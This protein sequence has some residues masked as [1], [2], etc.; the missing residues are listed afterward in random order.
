MLPFGETPMRY[1]G[2]AALVFCLALAAGTAQAE[3]KYDPGVSDSEIKLGQSMPYS[4]PASAYGALGLAELAYFKMLNE[5][6]GVNGRKINL[7]SLDDGYAPPK[8]VEQTR[9]LVE[10]E[11]VLAI[12]QSLGTPSNT[13]IQKY[14]NNKKVP[15]LF[16]ASGASKWGDPE[17]FPWTISWAPNYAAEAR[18]YAKAILVEHPDAK[19]AVLYQNDD[20]GKDYVEAFHNQLGAKAASLIVKEVSYEV[21][22][23]TI[24]SQVVTLKGAD[25]DTFFNVT[26]PKFAAMSIRKAYDI[27]WKPV[28]YLANVSNS[29]ASVLR[30]AG[31]EKAVGIISAAY[32]KDPND[33]QW[34]DDPAYKD[35]L[36]WMNKY[37]PLAD[38]GDVFNVYGYTVAETMAQVLRQC[39]DELTREN[40]MRQAA[41]LKDLRLPMLLPGIAINTSATRFYPIKQQRLERFDG[42]AWVLFGDVIG[43]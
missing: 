35:W 41:S 14:L 43:G 28:Q 20:F 9:K 32:L 1:R 42:K 21:S 34:Q 3:K 10:E 22:D 29:V 19:V 37:H 39:G 4:G 5:Q 13:A 25:A 8:A 33:K 31:L 38:K 18:I 16:I 30:P 27:G 7:I 26:T 17:H 2:S 15:Q 11:Q 12:F 40:L 24:D 23:P 36:A 6:G